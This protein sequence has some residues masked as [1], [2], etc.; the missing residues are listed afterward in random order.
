MMMPLREAWET[1]KSPDDA[2]HS[3]VQEKL[4]FVTQRMLLAF[5]MTGGSGEVRILLQARLQAQFPERDPGALAALIDAAI[6]LAKHESRGGPSPFS[7]KVLPS[8]V[9]LSGWVPRPPFPCE[10]CRDA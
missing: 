4:R 6:A 8:A 1:F 9:S 10:A 2:T 3:A 5:E 7:E